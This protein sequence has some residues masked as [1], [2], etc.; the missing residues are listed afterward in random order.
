MSEETYEIPNRIP[1]MTLRGVVLFPK[2]IM[3]LR[4]FEERYK[5][6]LRERL[7]D[8]R[9][10]AIVGERENV[11]EAEEHLELPFGVATAGLIR[12]SKVNPDGTS[13][14]LLQGLSRLRILSIPQEIPYRILEVEPLDTIVDDSSN[15][16][17]AQLTTQLKRN[18][19]LGG[20][21][22]EEIIEFLTPL[23]DD[24]AFVDLAAYSLCKSTIR[25]QALLEVQG[26]T[27]RATMLIDD[28]TRENDRLTLLNQAL[29]G[30]SDEDLGFN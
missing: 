27:K 16:L 7:E 23:D 12:V 10:F 26:F 29:G 21:V 8:N 2:A 3:P 4:I 18:L 19:A 9:I 28:L 13:F 20:D 14:V 25:K 24:I 11:S 1:A 5:T 30:K 15:G 17:R 22:T 6:M